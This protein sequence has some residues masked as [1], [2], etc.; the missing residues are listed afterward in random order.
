MWIIE[1]ALLQS[2]G[3]LAFTTDL[4][5]VT[6]LQATGRLTRLGASTGIEDLFGN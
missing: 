5:L 2:T 3:A 4:V 6:V 1:A